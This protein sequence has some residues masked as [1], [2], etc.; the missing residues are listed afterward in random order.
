MVL[1]HD[2]FWLPPCL[3]DIEPM[4]RPH[5]HCIW[6]RKIRC[7]DDVGGRLPLLLSHGCL[8]LLGAPTPR[9]SS[10]EM[11]AGLAMNT[12][13]IDPLG[14]SCM[15]PTSLGTSRS[16][17]HVKSWRPRTSL[18]CTINFQKL[19]LEGLGRTDDI[20]FVTDGRPGM[21]G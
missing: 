8:C 4:I 10:R 3:D 11:P 1:L 7:L 16:S 17:H 20:R 6:P 21:I 9:K 15:T 5:H 18:G 13:S 14:R 19:R 12:R 2:A